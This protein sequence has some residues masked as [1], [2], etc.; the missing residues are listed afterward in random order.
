MPDEIYARKRSKKESNNG[1]FFFFIGLILIFLGVPLGSPFIGF[2]LA[3]IPWAVSAQ[4]FSYSNIWHLGAMGEENVAKEL[5]RL[6]DSFHTIN[7]FYLPGQR[8]NFDHIVLGPNGIFL[9]ETKNHKGLISCNGDVWKQRKV[10][11]L[12]TVYDGV[13]K[14]PS[15]QVKANAAILNDFIKQRLKKNIW[16]NPVIVF[17]NDEAELDIKKSTVPVIRP[18]KLHGFITNYQSKKHL[19]PQ[20]LLEIKNTLNIQL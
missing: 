14:N 13:L 8:G 19:S 16:I 15:L 2:M 17:A 12:G 1:L 10:G 6:G 9:I 18:E 11:Q 7:D 20:E 4:Y 3:L 5:E